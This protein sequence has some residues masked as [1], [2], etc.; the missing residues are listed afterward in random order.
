MSMQSEMVY[1]IKNEDGHY[2]NAKFGALFT[3]RTSG[4]RGYGDEGMAKKDLEKLGDSYSM[5]H[6]LYRNIPKGERVYT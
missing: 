4:F 2:V 5:E 6:I 1:V 3:G